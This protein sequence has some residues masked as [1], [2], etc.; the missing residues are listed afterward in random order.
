MG[1]ATWQELVCD[2]CG[3]PAGDRN[4]RNSP[5]SHLVR[6]SNAEEFLDYWREHGWVYDEVNNQWICPICRQRMEEKGLIKKK[7]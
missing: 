1:H 2:K 3:V 5:D 4:I 6:N 7:R